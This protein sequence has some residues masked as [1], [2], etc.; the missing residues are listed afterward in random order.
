MG[1][2][3]LFLGR[4]GVLWPLIA[5]G[6]SVGGLSDVPT[7]GAFR[8]AEPSQT[9][10]TRAQWSRERWQGV[11]QGGQGVKATFATNSFGDFKL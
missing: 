8:R 6:A 2:G 5:S 7:W 11:T 3:R 1:Q 9:T 10:A 4:L